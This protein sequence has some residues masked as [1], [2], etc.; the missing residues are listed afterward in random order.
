MLI[1]IRS[2]NVYWILENYTLRVD[3]RDSRICR[4]DTRPLSETILLQTIAYI[5]FRKINGNLCSSVAPSGIIK[6][7]EAEFS[8]VCRCQK[9]SQSVDC[10]VP[11]SSMYWKLL[12]VNSPGISIDNFPLSSSSPAFYGSTIPFSFFTHLIFFP[13][14]LFLNLILFDFCQKQ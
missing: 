11:E 10:F 6:K 14:F 13:R 9:P 5:F 12:V 3:S 7:G 2:L 1:K 8:N 4:L